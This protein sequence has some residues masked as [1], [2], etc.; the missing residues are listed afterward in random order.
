MPSLPS[1]G[2]E[3]YV[4]IG[5]E[6]KEEEWKKKSSLLLTQ[7]IRC[8]VEHWSWQGFL[9]ETG[10]WFL[11][12]FS[13]PSNFVAKCKM[14]VLPGRKKFASQRST[15]APGWMCV[16]WCPVR[17]FNSGQLAA[18][19]CL[20]LFPMCDWAVKFPFLLMEMPWNCPHHSRLSHPVPSQS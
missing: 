18:H 17:Q 4:A 7:I 10:K 8:C 12:P 13:V 2:A 19:S 1:S 15:L 14:P 5:K 6:I 16:L 11:M 3:E 20:V 9:C